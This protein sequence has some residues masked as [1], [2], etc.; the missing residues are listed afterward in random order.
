V[1]P[2]EHVDRFVPYAHNS[3]LNIA[4]ELGIAGLLAW[5]ILSIAV[6]ITGVSLARNRSAQPWI[7]LMSAAIVGALVAHG[8]DQLANVPRAADSL[9]MWTL[10]GMAVAL[11]GIATRSKTDHGEE[12]TMA[13]VEPKKQA[14]AVALAVPAIAVIAIA[15]VAGVTIL[16]NAGHVLAD[17]AAATLQSEM[18][19]GA[20]V[21]DLSDTADRASGLAG[22]VAYYHSL[23]AEALNTASQAISSN[24][25]LRQGFARRSLDAKEA[26]AAAIPLSPTENL[27]YAAALSRHGRVTEAVERYEL[28]VRLS[29]RYW[30]AWLELA[31]AY[32]AVDRIEEGK[33]AL[34]RA[35]EL[36]SHQADVTRNDEV[37]LKNFAAVELALRVG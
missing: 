19:Q 36:I 8:V 22:D 24:P 9:S 29:P 10:I 28:A 18:I 11:A 21:S 12:P 33:A 15:V 32:A 4:T 13:S 16:A 31:G 1:A 25:S 7:R 35:E 23:E 37:N 26:A 3:F 30:A 2:D 20:L 5:T 17:R 34:S 6:V 14:S 27:A